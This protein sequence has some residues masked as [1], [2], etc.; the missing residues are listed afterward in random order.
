M[1]GGSQVMPSFVGM[2]VDRA[3]RILRVFGREGCRI[4]LIEVDQARG[5]VASQ[6]PA[7]GTFLPADASEIELVV[8]SDNPDRFLPEIFREWDL[9]DKDYKG[10]GRPL[11]LLK[12]FLFIP[13][14]VYGELDWWV[15]FSERNFD[16]ELAPDAFLPFLERIFPFEVY[17]GWTPRERRKV[18]IR[19]PELL[20]KRGTAEGIELMVELYTGMK[21][22]VH[23]MTWPYEGQVIGDVAVGLQ[24]VVS[25]IPSP[26]DAFYVELPSRDLPLE[27]IERI[28]RVV[29]AEKPAH[30]LYCLYAPP[31]EEVLEEHKAPLGVSFV[32]GD[33][34]ISGSVTTRDARIHAPECLP[35]RFFPDET[36]RTLARRDVSKQ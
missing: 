26:L 12:R 27:L 19:L 31:K 32:V 7:A 23:E 6:S 35:E 14:G 10:R 33:A 29:D 21:V 30:L 13:Q 5:R 4:R 15:D 2:H 22:K 16:A 20:R 8:E 1:T 3:R 34:V 25:Q 28:H 18:L 11:G 36:W 24:P 17:S 9:G